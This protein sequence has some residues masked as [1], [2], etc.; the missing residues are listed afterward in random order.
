MDPIPLAALSVGLVGLGYLVGS[1]RANLAAYDRGR[2]DGKREAVNSEWLDGYR[3]AERAYRD[4]L[5]QRA[6]PPE[7]WM[8]ESARAALDAAANDADLPPIAARTAALNSRKFV[9][10]AHAATVRP[11]E[12]QNNGE[13]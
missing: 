11:V 2:M 4:L 7:P 10:H 5:R 3:C 12:Q 13:L 1:A 8:R 9:P 6:D